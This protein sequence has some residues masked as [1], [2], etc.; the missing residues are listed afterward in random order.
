L[1]MQADA[2]PVTGENIQRPRAGFN[3]TG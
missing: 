1:S 3:G 2:T